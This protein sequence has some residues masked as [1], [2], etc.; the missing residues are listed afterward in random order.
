MHNHK[1]IKESTRN[2]EICND[3]YIIIYNCINRIIITVFIINFF[4][5]NWSKSTRTNET[6]LKKING[7]RIHVYYYIYYT[8]NIYDY[9]I[10]N[11][12]MYIHMYHVNYR[13]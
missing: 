13:S 10:Y 11:H 8:Y 6:V 5:A 7:M 2:L 3:I 9:C 12:T 4:F 1:K